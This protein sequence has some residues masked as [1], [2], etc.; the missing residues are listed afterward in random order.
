MSPE[1]PRDKLIDLLLREELG[2][3]APPDLTERILAR[4]FPRR[5]RRWLAVLAAAGLLLAAGLGWFCWPAS[6]ALSVEGPCEVVDGGPVRRGAAVRTADRPATLK[7]GGYCRVEL[8]QETLLKIEGQ[9][10]A[11]AVYLEA[12]EV[13]CTV[14]PHT[15]AFA[16]RTPAGTVSVVGTQFSVR[17]IEEKGERE[18]MNRRMIVSVLAGVV[19]VSGAWGSFELFAGDQREVPKAKEKKSGTAVG[20]LTAKGDIYIEVKADGEEKARRYT[21]HWIMVAP[22][23]GGLDPKMLEIIRGLKVGSRVKVQWEYDERARV[24]KVEVLK[25][26]AKDK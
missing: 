25:E 9:E 14:T 6:P 12:G 24:V 10:K 21:P 7:L 5:R 8:R 4:A 23:R 11:E 19:V 3:E 1:H 22:G 16:V 15:G 2:G 13:L 18:P 26:P 17:V 20:T